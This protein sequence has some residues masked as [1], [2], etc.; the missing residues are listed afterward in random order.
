MSSAG[1]ACIVLD[2]RGRLMAA[3]LAA[4]TLAGIAI[5]EIVGRQ[6]VPGVLTLIDFTVAARPADDYV[7]RIPPLLVLRS[8]APAR[9]L[10]RIRR[11]DGSRLTLDAV[12]AP[13]RDSGGAIGGSVAFFAA[14]PVT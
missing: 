2:A 11:D 4:S 6:L 3:S 14:V 8:G 9:G 7:D 10:L 12:A 13:L 5:D 1:D